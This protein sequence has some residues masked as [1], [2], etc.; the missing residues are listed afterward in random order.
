[1]IARLNVL[2]NAVYLSRSLRPNKYPKIKCEIWCKDR[3]SPSLPFL[4]LRGKFKCHNGIPQGAKVKLNVLHRAVYLSRSIR[5]NN[6]TKIK[7]Q[8]WSKARLSPFLSFLLLW[9]KFVIGSEHLRDPR[10]LCIVFCFEIS[11]LPPRCVAHRKEE[12]QPYSGD[13]SVYGCCFSSFLWATPKDNI[14]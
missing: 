7:C 9:G 8:I 14:Y 2:Y 6:H 13:S 4:L 1:M 5:P 10:T 11:N 12:K 3:L